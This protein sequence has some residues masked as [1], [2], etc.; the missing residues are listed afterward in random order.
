M[1]KKIFL[2]AT[3]VLILLIGAF[4]AIGGM[5]FLRVSGTRSEPTANAVGTNSGERSYLSA[6]GSCR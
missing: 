2:F 5:Q 4:F 6:C 3:I 1:L